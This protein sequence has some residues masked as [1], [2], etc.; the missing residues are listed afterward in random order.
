MIGHRRTPTKWTAFW[1]VMLF[2]SILSA[3]NGSVSQ[4]GDPFSEAR[5]TYS[6]FIINEE[7]GDSEEHPVASI[8]L[9]GGL[10]GVAI[11]MTV[12][13]IYLKKWGIDI[14]E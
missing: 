1:M 8:F 3:C 9:W 7:G 14:D 10:I 11:S 2:F 6:S 5:P 12:L 4:E 13:M